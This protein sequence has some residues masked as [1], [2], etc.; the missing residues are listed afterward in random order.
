MD[1]IM[2]WE[3]VCF[4]PGEG[5]VDPKTGRITVMTTHGAD[6]KPTPQEAWTDAE[7]LAKEHNT[8]FAAIRPVFGAPKEKPRRYITFAVYVTEEEP[9]G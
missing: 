5:R 4:V 1:D 3:G 6:T 9:E 2:G 7:A 8:Q